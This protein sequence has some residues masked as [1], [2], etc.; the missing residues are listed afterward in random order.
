MNT[1]IWKYA[2]AIEDE[3][4]LELREGADALCV[5]VQRGVPCL[6]VLLDPAAPRQRRLILTA[7]TGH[8][9]N[10]L[11]GERYIGTY[12]FAHENLVFHVFDGGPA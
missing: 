6:W 9:R 8:Q 2:L 1:T 5:E 3:Q 10:D 7:G 4:V 11:A 12:L